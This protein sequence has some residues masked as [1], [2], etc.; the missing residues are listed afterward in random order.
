MVTIAAGREFVGNPLRSR[1][2]TIFSDLR[3]GRGRVVAERW[4]ALERAGCSL[5]NRTVEGSQELN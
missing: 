3:G 1:D 5:S 4:Y 2:A